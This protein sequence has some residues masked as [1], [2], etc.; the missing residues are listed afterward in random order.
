M[1]WTAL[2]GTEVAEAI[3]ICH[4]CADTPGRACQATAA[5]FFIVS[6]R[7]N[8][9]STAK[10]TDAEVASVIPKTRGDGFLGA[11]AYRKQIK[12]LLVGWGLVSCSL[13]SP[14]GNGRLPTLY[15]FPMF[16]KLLDGI[17]PIGQDACD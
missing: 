3:R 15:G 13:Q 1:G 10:V 6:H 17:E 9:T 16:E 8:I 11:D 5:Y 2:C 4:T 14:T 12:S 7:S